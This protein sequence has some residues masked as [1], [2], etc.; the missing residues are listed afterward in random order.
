MPPC[1]VVHIL[2]P[3]YQ[4]NFNRP[5]LD[6]RSPIPS[7][8]QHA[9]ILQTGTTAPIIDHLENSASQ[10]PQ[11]DVQ[12]PAPPPSNSLTQPPSK[13]RKHT[14]ESNESMLP[15]PIDILL[16]KS[17]NELVTH[18]QENSKGS[19]SQADRDF[20]LEF[21]EEQRKLLA[22]KAIEHQLSMP[23]V[24]AFLGKRLA[25]KGPNCWNQFL[26]T[27]EA[28][29]IFKETGG[30][31]DQSAMKKVSELWHK[32]TPEEKKGFAN[33]IDD[34]LTDE[35]RALDDDN[36]EEL[37]VP[38][39]PA[40]PSTSGKDS[41]PTSGQLSVRTEGSFRHDYFTVQN[42]VND[43]V[44]KF[45]VFAVS[46][47]LGPSSYQISQC[48]PGANVF[49]TYSKDVDAEN[50]Y[51]AR[52]QSHITGYNVAQIAEL[53]DK[54]P[55]KNL[56][57]PS[58]EVKVTARMT[59]LIKAKTEGVVKRWPWTD[60]VSRLAE[61][62]FEI[63]LAPSARIN[64]DWITQPSRQLKVEH[65][66]SLH[67]D[68]DDQL[69]D[70]LRIPHNPPGGTHRAS[71]RGLGGGGPTGNVNGSLSQAGNPTNTNEGGAD[72]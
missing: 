24:D 72:D 2:P 35:E 52:F 22:I 67:L 36:S 69:I 39:E 30:V 54:T 62:G 41:V 21:Y 13:K 33:K 27:P 31:D 15:Q 20:F 50:H 5:I 60:T 12:V 48:T 47:H 8:N 17:Y 46:T 66:D 3:Q 63:A 10:T 45:V 16:K 28:R 44:A 40:A 70:I 23:M 51:A 37:I 34:G 4:D 19:M 42:F 71:P 58:H 65:I 7:L 18:A 56:K 64:F 68:L 25:L 38:V 57:K 9:A 1:S 43:F 53:A 59:S 55:K 14:V 6:T 61:I 29:A 26:K 49:L 11:L 32:L